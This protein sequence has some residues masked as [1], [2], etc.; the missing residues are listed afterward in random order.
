ML[1]GGAG[2]IMDMIGR[3]K[4]NEALRKRKSYYK[5]VQDYLRVT[6]GKRL[7]FR[8]ATPKEL[9]AI[10]QQIRKKRKRETRMTILALAIGSILAIGILWLIA[11]GLTYMMT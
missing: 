5:T 4:T 8:R 11:Q 2:H 10:R 7:S 6:G 9:A 1:G 3:I